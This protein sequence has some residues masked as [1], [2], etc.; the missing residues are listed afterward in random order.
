M[1][2]QLVSVQ[3]SFDGLQND[4]APPFIAYTICGLIESRVAHS[5][6]RSRMQ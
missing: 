1:N 3:R 5:A 4:D 2:L 6:F